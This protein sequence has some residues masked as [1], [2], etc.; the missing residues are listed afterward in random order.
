MNIKNL[1]R[2]KKQVEQLKVL[3]LPEVLITRETKLG[4]RSISITFDES[5]I[6][7]FLA[8]FRYSEGDWREP[9]LTE[10]KTIYAEDW[11]SLIDKVLKQFEP[12]ETGTEL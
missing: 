6:H 5:Q 1:F 2:N 11:P 4:L 9:G 7:T 12:E 8:H 10:E 3:K